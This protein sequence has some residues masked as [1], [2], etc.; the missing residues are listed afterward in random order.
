MRSTPK[1]KL[2]NTLQVTTSLRNLD[3]AEVCIIN[4]SALL[5]CIEWPPKSAKVSEIIYSIKKYIEAK[6]NTADVCLIFDRYQEFSPK[7]WTRDIRCKSDLTFHINSESM[8]P[9]Q[10]AMLTVTENKIQLIK[11]ICNSL[12]S[13]IQEFQKNNEC[14]NQFL[15][16]GPE[17]TPISV[18]LSVKINEERFG[19][20]S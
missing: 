4:G 12:P 5:Y 3:K 7:G 1:H 14:S 6:L 17:K 20:P 2:K 13:L 10:T 18:H 11:V 15:L 8:L 9:T 16:I 19:N